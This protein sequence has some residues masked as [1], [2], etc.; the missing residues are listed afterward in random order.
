[1][2]RT[3]VTGLW[4]DG[5]RIRG[6]RTSQGDIEAN[7]VINAAGVWAREIASLAGLDVPIVPIRGQVLFSTSLPLLIRPFVFHGDVEGR[8][9]F[10][11]QRPDGHILTGL[12]NPLEA[13]GWG[14]SVDQDFEFQLRRRLRLL[15]PSLADIPAERMWG[16]L[17]EV[18]PDTEPVIDMIQEPQGLV[19]SCGFSAQ[20][21][22]PGRAV[23]YYLAEWIAIGVR[24]EILALFALKRCQEVT[25]ATRQLLAEM[26][27]KRDPAA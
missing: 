4:I 1:M 26:S 8:R 16:G 23:G 21:F 18:T 22:G 5:A 25:A 3:G 6:V 15:A 19:L 13:E 7:W 27:G 20:G 24:L 17:Y 14:T 12:G 2:E 10:I 11:R 9:V